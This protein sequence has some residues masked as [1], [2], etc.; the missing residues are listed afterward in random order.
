MSSINKDNFF[1]VDIDVRDNNQERRKRYLHV[2][3]SMLSHSFYLILQYITFF[4]GNRIVFP[5]FSNN[6]QF[7]SSRKHIWRN[8]CLTV[9]VSARFSRIHSSNL[10]LLITKH[11]MN[12]FFVDALLVN[13]TSNDYAEMIKERIKDDRTSQDP[14]DYGAVTAT[15]VDAG[16]AHVSVLAPDGSAVSVTS[17]IN[18]L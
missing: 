3:L 11:L 9:C 4:S 13:L 12:Y 5:I 6:P 15:T 2:I 10:L 7:V 17:T 18:Q 16:T 8:Y 1:R 14:E